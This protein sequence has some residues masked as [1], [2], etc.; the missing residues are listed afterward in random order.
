MAPSDRSTPPKQ[1]ADS[2]IEISGSFHHQIISNTGWVAL[3]YGGL[4]ALA[5]L[6]TLILAHIL[7][8]SAFGLLAFATPLM[9]AINQL[10]EAGLG[11]AII[12]HRWTDMRATAASATAYYLVAGTVIAATIIGTAP[13]IAHFLGASELTNILRVLAIVP[14]ARAL[15][16]VPG[17]LVERELDFRRLAVAEL[18]AAVVQIAVAVTL[19]INGAGVWSLVAGQCAAAV[20]ESSIKWVVAPLRPSIRGARIAILRSMIG[21]SRAVSITNVVN[22][23]GTSID[24]L[25]VGKIS[26]TTTLGYY[27]QAY[28]LGTFPSNVLG[29]VVGRTMFPFYTKVRHDLSIAREIYV[30]NLQRV[31]IIAVPVSVVLMVIA[32]PMALVLLGHKWLPAVEPLQILAAFGLVKVI[33]SPS[34]ELFK[35]LG[36]PNLGVL[37]GSLYIVVALPLLVV[38][39]NADGASGAAWAMLFTM[40]V[41]QTPRFLISLRLC[42]LPI[43][44]LGSALSPAFA[45]SFIIG[46]T[47]LLAMWG[48]RDLGPALR[49]TLLISVAI[50]SYAATSLVF[51]RAT[52]EP[53]WLGLRQAVQ[54]A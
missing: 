45:C 3:S 53:L 15:G 18:S 34:G 20:M 14:F 6:S 54:N 28:R 32:K 37:F 35:G 36:R 42:H 52:L 38:L 22:L 23:V 2:K 44:E 31:A 50:A 8:P 41:T 43:R 33:Y 27:S 12:Y 39:V 9:L 11:S 19:A 24:N 25:T 4:N 1:P 30:Q 5:M 26:G 51:A 21:Y 46:I 29:Y 10:Q 17:A 48:T 47:M 13:Y 49:L 16:V 40:T 7:T